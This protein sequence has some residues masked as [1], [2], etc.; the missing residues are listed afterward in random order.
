MS[1]TRQFTG[2]LV[3]SVL[4]LIA[5]LVMANPS[6]GNSAGQQNLN[7]QLSVEAWP[8]DLQSK[9]TISRQFIGV[10]EPAQRVMLSFERSAKL[11][12]LLVEEG[13]RV[14]AGELLAV[15]D[16]ERLVAERQQVKAAMARAAAE[17]QIAQ[18][19]LERV[20]KL[21]D[22]GLESPQALDEAQARNDL[23]Q[24]QAEE[25]RSR[26]QRL[27]VEFEKSQLFAPFGGQIVRQFADVGTQ[28]ASGSPVFELNSVDL[29]E[30]RI[31]LPIDTPARLP[32]ELT[33]NVADS[34]YRVT[35]RSTSEMVSSRTRSLD[36]RV[37]FAANASLKPGQLFEL[38]VPQAIKAVGAWVPSSSLRAG[39]QGTWYVMALEPVETGYLLQHVPVAIE[40]RRADGMLYVTGAIAD[41]DQIV[42]RG[43]HRFVNQQRVPKITEVTDDWAGMRKTNGR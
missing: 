14:V 32:E 30:G 13:E 28:L 39:I 42:A 25:A 16:Q 18:L 37:T 11:V 40:Y 20:T 8:V 5:L 12:Q 43:V 29:L 31:S 19:S 22:Q 15:L 34:V 27:E 36:L 21:V 9:Y 23:A 4:V 6:R 26:L 24:A 35:K 7:Q 3:V 41:G 10:V 1:A 17:V 38:Q 33:V 2:I